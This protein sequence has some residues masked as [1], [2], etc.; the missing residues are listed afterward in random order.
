MRYQSD[1]KIVEYV[2]GIYIYPADKLFKKISLLA[3]KKFGFF[4]DYE[5]V[6]TYF[7]L[8][9]KI[10]KCKNFEKN[11]RFDLSCVEKIS[12]DAIMYMIAF[13]KTTGHE[14]IN[15]FLNIPENTKCKKFILSCGIG[16]FMKDKDVFTA[17]ECEDYYAIEFGSKADTDTAKK[18]SDFVYK[19]L[20]INKIEG[21]FLYNMLIELMN[22]TEQHAYDDDEKKVWYIFIENTR[23][24][25]K[26][27]FLDTGK[28]IPA[29]ISIR[30]NFKYDG[31]FDKL[32]SSSSTHLLSDHGDNYSDFGDFSFV[33]ILDSISNRD[34]KLIFS[35]L[36]SNSNRTKTKN[37]NRGR[38]LPEIYN[39]YKKD[40]YTS[41]F[42][43][44]S[45][46]GVCIFK[47]SKRNS[48]DMIDLD[49]AFNGTLFYWEIKKSRF[50][51]SDENEI[52]N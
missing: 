17:N 43:I 35:A 9:R 4:D 21:Y 13:V 39:Y 14:N 34:S 16:N 22:N 40:K 27:T 23:N 38:G 12:I 2:D 6:I 20:G 19:K 47:D 28:G 3:P 18:I 46:N 41:K 7:D 45:R 42:K 15:F 26:C 48:P 36:M 11:L 32:F 31:D 51:R 49:I 25:I 33:D 50:K 44:I 1:I 24:K 8:A 10:C 37:Y 29:T 5:E 30:N 52:K